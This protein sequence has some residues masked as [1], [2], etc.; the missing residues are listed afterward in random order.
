M[1]AWLPARPARPGRRARSVENLAVLEA[2]HSSF[3]SRATGLAPAQAPRAPG[4]F[5]AYPG[6]TMLNPSSMTDCVHRSPARRHPGRVAPRRP[7]ANDSGG[8][9]AQRALA[10]E[11]SAWAGRVNQAGEDNRN[12]ARFAALLSGP[13]ADHAGRH[14]ERLAQAACR[15]SSIRRA[16]SPS[17]RQLY[18]AGGVESMAAAVRDGQVGLPHADVKLYRQH[19]RTRFPNPIHQAVRDHSMPADRR[20]RWRRLR[21]HAQ[22]G[23][24]VRAPRSSRSTPLEKEGF[25]QARSTRHPAPEEK[26]AAEKKSRLDEHPRRDTSWTTRRLSRCSKAAWVT[27]ARL[28]IN[29]VQR[30]WSWVPAGGNSEGKN[31]CRNPGRGGRRRAAHHGRRAGVC[32]SAR[33]ERA[34]LSL[35]TWDII[36]INEPRSQVLR[37]PQAAERR[38]KDRPS[39]RSGAIA[40][41]HPLGASARASRHGRARLQQSGARYAASRCA[42]ASQGLAVILKDTHERAAETKPSSLERPAAPRSSSPGRAHCARCRHDSAREA[43]A[44]GIGGF[45]NEV[46]DPRIFQGLVSSACWDR[47]FPP[48]TAAR[49]QLRRLRLIAREWSAVDSGYRSMMTCSPRRHAADLPVRAPKRQRRKNLPKLAKANGSPASASPSPDHGSIPAR[50]DARRSEGR[51]QPDGHKT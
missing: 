48:S 18:I 42:S 19:H 22:P 2:M 36:E 44:P 1:L 24:R 45:R 39:I 6:V 33:L 26:D 29:D 4:R 15:R 43:H 25:F 12:V 38:L 27:R 34:G 47:P 50:S 23:R 46:T 7:R 13:A 3:W 51:L 37:L 41:R 21:H 10:A 31:D 20:T 40:M 32:H 14:G 28:G 30:R 9:R 5:P 35:R 49:A 16:P 11:I 8:R 17:R